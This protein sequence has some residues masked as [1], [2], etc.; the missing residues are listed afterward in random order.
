MI[1]FF[2]ESVA[3]RADAAGCVDTSPSG[4]HASVHRGDLGS[5]RGGHDAVFQALSGNRVGNRRIRGVCILHHGPGE[6][7]TPHLRKVRSPQTFC[8]R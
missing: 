7:M 1:A 6:G 2:G 8:Y 4:F 3:S 5:G